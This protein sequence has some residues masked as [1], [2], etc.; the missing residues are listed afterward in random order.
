VVSTENASAVRKNTEGAFECKCKSGYRGD[1]KSCAAIDD[2][3]ADDPDCTS[4]CAGVPGG[5]AKQDNCGVCDDDETNDCET[6][7]DLI[8]GLEWERS[9]SPI[10]RNWTGAL[11]YCETSTFDDRNDWRL[12]N[13]KEL[14]SIVDITESP[15]ISS[16]FTDTNADRYWRSSPELPLTVA[17]KAYPVDFQSG[18]GELN[19][20]LSTNLN[21]RCV[22]GP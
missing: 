1:G 19:V 13:S 16:L 2:C 22:R 11:D 21:V 15:M 5:S 8:T 12:P 10:S 20:V 6:V 7:I 3:P 14:Y 4:D 18:V 17:D 9:D